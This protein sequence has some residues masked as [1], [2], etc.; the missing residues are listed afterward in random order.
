MKCTS[1]RGCESAMETELVG[2]LIDI[3]NQEND[4]YDTLYKISNNKKE[5][6]IAGKVTE[7]E[8]I[9]KIE[10]SLII[11]ISRLEDAREDI[12][13]ELCGLLG[14]KPENITIS[15]L[16]TRLGALEAAQLKACQERMVKNINSLKD[17]NELNSRLIKNSLEYIDFSINMMTSIDTMSNNY[18]NTGH[19]GDTKKRNLFDVKL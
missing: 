1:V 13:A 9:V 12:V 5:L 8:N 4:I 10:Q 3:L 7:L 15:W 16:T 18:G 2:Q 11:K 19:S 17:N 6:I 14:Q